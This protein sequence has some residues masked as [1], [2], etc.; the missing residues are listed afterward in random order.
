MVA[1]K[2]AI[3]HSALHP[4][5]FLRQFVLGLSRAVVPWYNLVFQESLSHVAGCT[6]YDCPW[7]NVMHT[8]VEYEVAMGWN[9]RCMS[10]VWHG[11]TATPSHAPTSFP[12]TH[13]DTHP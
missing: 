2:F 12:S 1:C 3:A 7:N 4:P 9:L 10:Y 6:Q 8:G 5:G 13:M 11:T